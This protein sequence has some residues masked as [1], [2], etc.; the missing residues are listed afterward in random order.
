MTPVE[1][2]ASLPPAAQTVCGKVAS[3]LFSKAVGLVAGKIKPE[4]A[5]ATVYSYFEKSFQDPDRPEDK[6]NT[7]FVEFF[8]RKRV[9]KELAKLRRDRYKD[10]DFKVLEEELRGSFEFAGCPLPDTN[11]SQEIDSWVGELRELLKDEGIGV[12]RPDPRPSEAPVENDTRAR[13]KYLAWVL[14]EHRNIQ[15][16]GMALVDEQAGVELAR[17]FVIPR[18]IRQSD[19]SKPIA[20]KPA[21][22]ANKILT[23]KKCPPRLVILGGPG[24]GKTTL[25]GVCPR[26]R[27]IAIIFGGA[28]KQDVPIM[29]Y[30][31]E[32]PTVLSG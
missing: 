13:Q 3:A 9:V 22:G 27:E 1:I 15:F 30:G 16:S 17:V 31:Q 32:L 23:A 14:R 6:L 21:A 19:S 18:L 12:P 7:A 5:I 2:Y 28:M 8:C 4:D 29:F 24:S 26:N 20:E 25:L 11:L 10:I